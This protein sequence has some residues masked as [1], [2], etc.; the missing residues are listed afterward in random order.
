MDDGP[1]CQMYEG[2]V[3]CAGD[4]VLP[5]RLDGVTGRVDWRADGVPSL[6]KKRSYFFWLLG[7][8]DDVMLVKQQYQPE[9][10][11]LVISVIALDTRTGKRL[12]HRTVDLQST[13]VF[14]SGDLVLVPD[15]GRGKL[16][17][18]SARTGAE[19][20][21]A[22]LSPGVRCDPAHADVGLYLECTP[23]MTRKDTVLL[24]LD[25]SDGSVRRLTV[26]SHATLIGTYDGRL[27]YLEAAEEVPGHLATG[28]KGPFSRIRLVDPDTGAATTT[29]LA[30]EY[31]GTATSADGTLWFTGASGQVTAVSAR[32]GKQLWQTQTSLE[33]PGG[34]TP[35]P[36]ARVVYLSSA[37]GR[38]AALDAGKGTLLWETPPHA[39][40]VNA[41]SEVLPT[42]L[43]HKG[44]LVV[45]TPSGDM[46]TVDPAH[47]E[48]TSASG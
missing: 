35:A 10:G 3:Y 9:G 18:R 19:R 26:P 47:P 11:D 20:W 25:R 16:T 37:S 15:T 24:G 38:V 32:T 40:W 30:K 39:T 8:A 41:E 31:E 27:L 22:P 46:F 5:V 23:G 17:A 48:R 43:L 42:V 13:H 12:W 45:T 44:A 4:A 7:V 33:Q 21:T 29:E 34:V 36:R 28:D 6:P 2:A 1:E 14:A